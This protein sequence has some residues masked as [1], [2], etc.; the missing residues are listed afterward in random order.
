M[1]FGIEE[2]S[3]AFDV[4]SSGLLIVGII[5]AGLTSLT[6]L[7]DYTYFGTTAATLHVAS[8]WLPRL[9]AVSLAGCSGVYSAAS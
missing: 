8:G 6:L 4:A 1:V 5:A 7:G 3:R 9:Y 2:M